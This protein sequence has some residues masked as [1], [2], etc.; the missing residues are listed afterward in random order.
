MRAIFSE[1]IASSYS[2]TQ[3]HRCTGRKKLG[4][5]KKFSRLFHIGPTCQKIFLANF[6]SGSEDKDIEGALQLS[7]LSVT[8]W[9]AR[10]ES[11]VAVMWASLDGII[12]A[13]D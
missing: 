3:V 6:S 13:L 4:G 11:I 9:V 8:R 12:A 7:N 10:S 5:T 2:Y 1:P